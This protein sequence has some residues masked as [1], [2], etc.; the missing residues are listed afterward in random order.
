MKYE[1]FTLLG[2]KDIGVICTLEFKAKAQFLLPPFD[3]HCRF[4]IPPTEGGLVTVTRDVISWD[5]CM[6]KN[7]RTAKF[8]EERFAHFHL[9]TQKTIKLCSTKSS[10]QKSSVHNYF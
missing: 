4:M 1:R 9:K 10:V 5:S 3:K 2:C 6:K 7:T 8:S